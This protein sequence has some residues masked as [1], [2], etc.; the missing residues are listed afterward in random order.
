[1]GD[2]KVEVKKFTGEVPSGGKCL[3]TETAI[4][5][6]K[7]YATGKYNIVDL[8]KKFG[9]SKSA[10]GYIIQGKR[11]VRRRKCRTSKHYL[12]NPSEK[13]R[14][15]TELYEVKSLVMDT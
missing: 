8:A 3:S 14:I 13:N 4:I 12:L 2:S 1:M 5:I 10:V 15:L 6:R 9:S 11:Y 7:L